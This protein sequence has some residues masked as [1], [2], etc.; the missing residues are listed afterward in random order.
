MTVT[1]PLFMLII[2]AALLIFSGFC[3]GRAYE[4]HQSYKRYQD[5]V[6]NG[7]NLWDAQ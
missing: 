3:F 2:A 5:I 6:E 7:G 4:A 1:V